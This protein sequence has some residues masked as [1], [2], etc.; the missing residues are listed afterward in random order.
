MDQKEEF[1]QQ[2]FRQVNYPIKGEEGKIYIDENRDKI[3]EIYHKQ[4][5][6]LIKWNRIQNLLCLILSVS[7]VMQSIFYWI[8][9]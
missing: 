4:F 8:I 2:I 6:D 5:E 7:L 3:L 1:N 9:K